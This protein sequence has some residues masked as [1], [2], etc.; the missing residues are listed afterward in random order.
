MKTMTGNIDLT[1][2]LYYK[3]RLPKYTLEENRNRFIKAFL[4]CLKYKLSGESTSKN[5]DYNS[6]YQ[7]TSKLRQR[8]KIEG[9]GIDL[10]PL[11]YRKEYKFIPDILFTNITTE[12][13]AKNIETAL[14]NTNTK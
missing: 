10:I 5:K 12:E 14:N 7:L 2:D 13:Q 8:L 11:E 3:G 6:V 9:K 4:L 1:K